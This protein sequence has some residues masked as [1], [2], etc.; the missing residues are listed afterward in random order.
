M[1]LEFTDSF[2]WVSENVWVVLK[3]VFMNASTSGQCL[4]EPQYLAVIK[5]ARLG[6]T[7]TKQSKYPHC[8]LRIALQFLFD[9]CESLQVFV[10]V[11]DRH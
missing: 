3:R 9:P 1:F 5:R 10:L 2:D 4:S 8:T 7:E 6:R 11:L